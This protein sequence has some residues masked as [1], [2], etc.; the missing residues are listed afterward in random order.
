V[1]YRDNRIQEAKGAW[2]KALTY[3]PHDEVTRR[4]LGEFVIIMSNLVFS[5]WD[6]I[7][8]DAMTTAAGI[9]RLV[10][11]SVMLELASTRSVRND[12]AIERD[13]NYDDNYQ[14]G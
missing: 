1:Y 7:F 5:Q 13:D 14:A 4:N 12:A 11:H 3:A 2:E 10:H 6:R 9:D 8:K